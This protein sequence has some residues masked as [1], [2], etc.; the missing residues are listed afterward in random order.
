MNVELLEKVKAAILA[1]PKAFDM[2]TW[3]RIT[4]PHLGYSHWG[5]TLCDS[6]DEYSSEI[7]LGCNTTHCIAGWAE[8][9]AAADGRVFDSLDTEHNAKR[10]LGLD[11][12]QARRLFYAD[13]W[14]FPFDRDYK[15]AAKRAKIAAARI[16]HFIATNGEE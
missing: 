1:E 3:H 7:V 16:D 6:L 8:V 15:Y 13:E 11:Y 2:G 10:L 12:T 14:P 4:S 9:I 5:D